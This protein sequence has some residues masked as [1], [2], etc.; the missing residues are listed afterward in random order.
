VVFLDVVL[1]PIGGFGFKFFFYRCLY[2]KRKNRLSKKIKKITDTL[3]GE[4]VL[5]VMNEF[6]EMGKHTAIMKGKKTIVIK[7][8]TE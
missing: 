8:E 1:T 6:K 3:I 2:F 4:P 5:K 7:G